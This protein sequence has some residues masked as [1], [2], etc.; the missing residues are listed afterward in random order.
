MANRFG[1]GK[2]FLRSSNTPTTPNSISNLLSSFLT[3]TSILLSPTHHSYLSQ[4]L[5]API[6]LLP[7]QKFLSPFW[8]LL[9]IFRNAHEG[10]KNSP[11][12]ESEAFCVASSH[13]A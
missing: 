8:E 7:L 1:I 5:P 11:I 12:G 4:T 9:Y 3:L 13:L 10:D 2:I 6:T